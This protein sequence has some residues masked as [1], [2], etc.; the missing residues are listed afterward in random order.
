[1]ILIAFIAYT[2]ACGLMILGNSVITAMGGGV[3]AL[4]AAIAVY[5]CGHHDGYQAN[6]RVQEAVDND[7]K[8]VDKWV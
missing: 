6:L 3:F 7:T 5:L 4:I 8:G 1:M 2:I